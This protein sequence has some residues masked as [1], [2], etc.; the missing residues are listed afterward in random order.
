MELKLQFRRLG[1][2][3]TVCTCNDSC[4]SGAGITLRV[5]YRS[6]SYSTRENG[7][8]STTPIE[9]KFHKFLSFHSSE[10]RFYINYIHSCFTRQNMI[11]TE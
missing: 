8:I 7:K 2:G 3:F 4:K 9:L 11:N 6:E 10:N 1:E 5:A